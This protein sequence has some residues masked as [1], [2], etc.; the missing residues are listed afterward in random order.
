[1]RRDFRKGPRNGTQA[2]PEARRV[3]ADRAGR[4]GNLEP[5]E[6]RILLVLGRTPQLDLAGDIRT[7]RIEGAIE[8]DDE[9]EVVDAHAAREV[10]LDIGEAVGQ[11]EGELADRV[12][13]GFGDVAHHLQRELGGEE[14]GVLALVFLQDVGLHRAAH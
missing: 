9:R 12:G 3:A 13:A 8:V 1:M 5:G 11:R 7:L 10:G 6:L 2:L 4:K 14:A